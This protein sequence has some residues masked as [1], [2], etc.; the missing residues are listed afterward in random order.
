[1]NFE[2]FKFCFSTSARESL[3]NT[4]LFVSSLDR[5]QL[6]LQICETV[7]I[8]LYQD[9][10][11][12]GMITQEIQECYSTKSKI[13]TMYIVFYHSC[14]GLDEKA[15][16]IHDIALVHISLWMFRRKSTLSAH[17]HHPPTMTLLHYSWTLSL[18]IFKNKKLNKEVKKHSPDTCLNILRF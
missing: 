16:R 10:N 6:L 11:R 1:M 17:Y 3:V 9:N 2:Q 15:T 13:R 5:L 4:K 7:L 12:S 18:H 14:M 8:L